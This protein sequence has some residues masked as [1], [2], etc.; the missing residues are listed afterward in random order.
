[1]KNDKAL[2]QGEKAGIIGIIINLL[3]F[4]AKLTAGILSGAVSIIA[5]SINNLSDSGS[6]IIS[7]ISFKIAQKPADTVAS[8]KTV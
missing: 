8:N 7:L 6:A 5:D 4:A 2:K 1:M 3:L